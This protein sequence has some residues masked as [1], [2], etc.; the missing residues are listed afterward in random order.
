MVKKLMVLMLVLLVCCVLLWILADRWSQSKL[1]RVCA[2]WPLI[3]RSLADLIQVIP[4]TTANQ[5]AHDL[6][7]LYERTRFDVGEDGQV[8]SEHDQ[9]AVSNMRQL[10]GDYLEQEFK[11]SNALLESPSSH[12]LTML[13]YN[14]DLLN[15]IA[16]RLVNDEL[17]QLSLN[18][19]A[20]PVDSVPN[21]LWSIQLSRLLVVQALSLQTE[22][23]SEQAWSSLHAAARLADSSFTHPTLIYQLI[24]IAEANWVLLAMRKM[25]ASIPS[26]ALSWPAHDLE[27]GMI[28][29][30]ITESRYTLSIEKTDQLLPLIHETNSINKELDR[31]D[32]IEIGIGTRILASVV[33]RPYIRAGI[34][35]ILEA[36]KASITERLE[37][38]LCT[39]Q[40]KNLP[41][42]NDRLPNWVTSGILGKITSPGGSDGRFNA[43]WRRAHRIMVILAGTRSILAAKAASSSTHWPESLAGRVSLPCET[44]AWSYTLMPDGTAT[45]QYP[46]PLPSEPYPEVPE[47]HLTYIGSVDK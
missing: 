18:V 22:G 5:A 13:T 38:R 31:E 36:Y 2:D 29:S 8:P 3:D 41:L 11:R 7:A 14:K 43:P 39:V 30:F 17:P 44:L 20:D 24:G 9:G 26:W 19:E 10:L 28:M 33:G 27:H 12:I 32:L 46:H 25:S 47:E 37:E 15:D 23:K 6:Q 45:F 34:A 16:S 35:H 40:P 42:V 1:E 21:L 4:Q